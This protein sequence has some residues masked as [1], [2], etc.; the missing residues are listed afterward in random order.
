ME[1]F[2]GN[3]TEALNEYQQKNGIL[4]V[5]IYAENEESSSKFNELWNGF[6]AA[7]TINVPYVAI[8]LLKG[9]AGAQQFAEFFPT[10]TIPICYILGRNAQPL[11]VCT[12]LQELT[13]EKLNHS[14]EKAIGL[15]KDQL[16]EEGIVIDSTS[17]SVEKDVNQSKEEV[18][19]DS[20]TL[21]EENVDAVNN[22]E[23]DETAEMTKE[24]K[25]ERYRKLLEEKKKVDAKKNEEEER[26]KEIQRRNEGKALAELREKQ[27][28][29]ELREAAEA[30][31]KQ[32][33]AD[34]Q[35][36][37]KLRD[38][39]KADK[40]ERA[41]RN[42][43]AVA[44]EHTE[45]AKPE[46]NTSAQTVSEINKPIKTDECKIQCRFPDGSTLNLNYPSKEPLQTVYDAVNQD[47]RKP[48]NFFLI[49]TYPRK[50]L[51]EMSKTLLD[52]GL[53][54]SAVVLVISADSKKL[55]QSGLV[56]STGY[57]NM[58]FG[59]IYLPLN[60]IFRFF[61]SLMGGGNQNDGNANKAKPRSSPDQN[62]AQGSSA[63]GNKNFRRFKS[64]ESDHSDTEATWNGNSTQQL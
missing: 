53:T 54:P 1:W 37:K 24:E 32:K 60:A 49:Q 19:T 9:S 61:T 55:Q 40:E 28:D 44:T 27:R 64:D 31:R 21:V 4:I 33:E 51:N 26:A 8:R 39:I 5:Y 11:E 10:I 48:N 25:L 14:F 6:D 62:E 36:L 57:L 42:K 17:A 23:T 30:R 2:Q 13:A 45:V 52:L 63:E 35:A 50:K 29:N 41:K 58:L 34:A 7:S 20:T 15:Y 38:Q 16:K 12:A 56:A 46:S 3:V 59:L 18:F 43:G 22:V 47:P